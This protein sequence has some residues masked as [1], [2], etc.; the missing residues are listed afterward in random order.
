VTATEHARVEAAPGDGPVV[1][2]AEDQVEDIVER[3]AERLAPR[4]PTQ[5]DGLVDAATIARE[6]GVARATV[7]ANKDALGAIPVGTGSKPRLRFDRK[8]AVEGWKPG[9]MSG[10]VE[11]AS[12]SPKQRVRL[13]GRATS[14]VELLP[15]RGPSPLG[16]PRRAETIDRS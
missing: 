4:L 14:G 6:L 3:I 16:G 1:R 15:V 7:Y 10:E 11:A 8:R 13:S 9:A 2:L 5:E 12:T